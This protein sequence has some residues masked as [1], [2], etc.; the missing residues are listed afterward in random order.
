MNPYI[1]FLISSSGVFIV[2]QH[3][4][5]CCS[6]KNCNSGSTLREIVIPA[7]CPSCS[8]S[9]NRAAMR[10]VRKAASKAARKVARS[11]APVISHPSG[12]HA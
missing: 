12:D 7:P 2:E 9:E 11:T 3:Q 6:E 5:R 1:H 10:R 8:D 4:P